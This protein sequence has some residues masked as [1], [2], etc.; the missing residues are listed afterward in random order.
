MTKVIEVNNLN[1]GYDENLILKNITFSVEKGDFMGIIG[2]NGSGK[3]TLLK[4]LLKILTP[5]SGEIKLLGEKIENFKEWNKIGYISQKATSFNSSFP[6]TVEEIV[7]ANLFSKVGLFRF[8][9]RKHR[10][11]VLNALEIVGMQDYRTRLIGTLSGGQQQRVFI[12]RVLVS[13][14]EIMFLDEPTIGIDVKSEEAVYCLLARLN[15]EL[16]LTVVMVTHDISA[17]TVH[18]NKIACLGGK[19]LVIHDP[20]EELTQEIITE[21]YGYGVN[22]HIHRHNCVNC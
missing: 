22:L 6:A 7:G 11:Q 4:I 16:G 3:S 15:R 12:A 14:P 8:L 17:V 21:L 2:A 9:T 1:F 10:E 13:E 18:A 19:G 5:Q 20:K